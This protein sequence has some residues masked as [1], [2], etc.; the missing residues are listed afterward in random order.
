MFDIKDIKNP[1]FLK[2][3]DDEALIGLAEDIRNFMIENVSKTGGHLSSNLSIV[4][5]VISLYR[6][7]DLKQDEIIFDGGYQCYCHKILT[8]RS[9]EFSKL[10]KNGGISGYFN[11]QESSYD[12]ENVPFSFGLSVAYGKVL[13][14]DLKGE[15]KDVVCVVGEETILNGNSL[16]AL[17]MIGSQKK[18]MIIVLNDNGD[19]RSRPAKPKIYRTINNLRNNNEYLALKRQ[20]KK[21]LKRTDAGKTILQNVSNIKN[22][23]KNQMI[24]GGIISSFGIN[25]YGPVNGHDFKSLQ[26]AINKA[27]SEDGPIL[28]HVLTKKGRGYD[29]LENGLKNER[30]LSL[31][32]DR[33]TGK[34][35]I[36]TPR[37]YKSYDDITAFCLDNLMSRYDKVVCVFC[38]I[39]GETSYKRIIAKYP[40][41]VFKC[42]C[43]EDH[44]VSVAY[45]LAKEGFFPFLLIDSSY[46]DRCI[47]SISELLLRYKVPVVIGLKNAG[48]LSDEGDEKQGIFDISLLNQYD[49]LSIV[50]GHDYKEIMNLLYLGFTQKNPYFFRI[51][52]LDVKM[53]ADN[54][55]M[56]DYGSWS[57]LRKLTDYK[58]TV[59]SYGADLDILYKEITIN[60]LPYQLVN[61]RFIKPID[62]KI[63]LELFRENKKIVVYSSDYY[64]NG[65]YDEICNFYARM[66]APIIN[67]AIH[68]PVTLGSISQIKKVQK[69]DW[70][71]IEEELR[72]K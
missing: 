9:S 55:T 42:G 59:I 18:K 46:L 50:L 3:L 34:A 15:D 38:D 54:E 39:D 57:Y 56:I 40:K 47:G 66:N 17:N 19:Y 48:L 8:G 51:P 33:K 69:M 22:N 27:K 13:S 12:H 68:M 63:L 25:Y 49:S 6:N 28:I 45:A 44:A 32:F 2:D 37:G 26:K 4:E 58:A 71:D 62:K 64:K 35:I 61:A 60:D 53:S 7:F 31:P 36:S 65:L 29:L 5:L 20:I 23:I 67:E 72:K 1:D 11:P 70:V 24:D 10:R 30:E 16:E 52:R 41:R 14:R 43:F 21:T